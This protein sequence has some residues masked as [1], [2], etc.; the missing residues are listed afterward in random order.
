MQELFE[1]RPKLYSVLND[2][3]KKGIGCKSEWPP[4]SFGV[5][6]RS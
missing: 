6:V 2:V 4:Y 5:E 1:A 3:I